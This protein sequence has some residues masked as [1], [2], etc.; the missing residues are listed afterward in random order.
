MG[1]LRGVHNSPCSTQENKENAKTFIY[2]EYF[3]FFLAKCGILEKASDTR[4][5][6]RSNW[7]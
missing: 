3:F 2:C 7:E 5:V 1:E 6:R 4:V